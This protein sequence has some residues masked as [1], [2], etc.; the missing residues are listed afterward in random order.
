M[1]AKRTALVTGASYGVG[2]ATALALARDGFDVA[3]TA[4]KLDNLA[5]T[6]KALGAAGARALPLV[7]DLREQTTIEQATANAMTTFGG[8]DVLVNN[9]GAN[10]RRLAVDVTAQDWDAVMAV[11]IRGTFFLTQQVGRHLIATGRSGCIVNIAST[12][13][14]AGTAERSTYGISKAALLGMTRM[15]AVE[16]A[17]YGIRVNAIAPGRLETPSPSR[18]EKGADRRYMDTMLERIPLHRLA[19]AEEVAA[20]VGYLVSP[21]AA[22]MTGQ[23][24]VLDGGLTAA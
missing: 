18:A 22:S 20:T 2:A 1:A 23:V 21:A 24:L 16:W 8:L 4:T 5:A 17:E 14:L 6:M 19:S 13:A 7:L 10:V 3:V 12:H 11:N 15:L 9:A